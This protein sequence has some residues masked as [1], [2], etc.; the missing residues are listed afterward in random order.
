MIKLIYKLFKSELNQL[1]FDDWH[2]PNKMQGLEFAFVFQGKKW[3]SYSDFN[4]MPI[5]RY[6]EMERLNLEMQ[7]VID[8]KDMSVFTELIKSSIEMMMIKGKLP[9]GMAQIS[10]VAKEM[11]A[12]QTMLIH[13]RIWFEIAA[14]QYIREDE[15]P[16]LYNHSWEQSKAELF[17]TNV[18][19][20]GGLHGFFMQAGFERYIPSLAKLE[21]GYEQL[22]KQQVEDLRIQTTY[23]ASLISES[24]ST[25]TL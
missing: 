1:A 18:A 9:Q 25:T 24:K 10:A 22:W 21:Q 15:D 11:E 7:N 20:L 8:K 17:K 19:D 3:Y 14:C 12:R 16:T 5:A 2:K 6:T 4:K 23:L 13:E